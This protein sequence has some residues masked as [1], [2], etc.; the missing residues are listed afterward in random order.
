MHPRARVICLIL[1]PRRSECT[2]A[3]TD[4]EPT[5]VSRRS[6]W[7][8]CGIARTV[9]EYHLASVAAAGPRGLGPPPRAARS[10]REVPTLDVDWHPKCVRNYFF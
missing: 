7:L 10:L 5:K 8:Q 3:Q 9:A 1:R 2:A 6:G 4:Q